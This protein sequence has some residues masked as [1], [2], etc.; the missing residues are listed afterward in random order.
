M[1]AVTFASSWLPWR[2]RAAPPLPRRCLP[3]SLAKPSR[4]VCF[5]THALEWE[6]T[7]AFCCARTHTSVCHAPVCGLNQPAFHSSSFCRSFPSVCR[8][9]SSISSP[10]LHPVISPPLSPRSVPFKSIIFCFMLKWRGAADHLGEY[11][12]SFYTAFF[13]YV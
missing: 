11:H 8:Y 10:H 1:M 12:I 6:T 7:C 3:L 5:L 9:T 13:L 2:R 4:E